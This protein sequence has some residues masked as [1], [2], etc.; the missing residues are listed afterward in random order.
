MKAGK[1]GGKKNNSG[2]NGRRRGKDTREK[3]LSVATRLFAR[4]GFAGT[5][6]DEIA[7]EVGIKKASLYHHFSSKHEIYDE[8]VKRVLSEIMQMFKKSFYSDDIIDDA[9][10]F[11]KEVSFFVAKNDDYLKILVREVLDEN[12]PIRELSVKYLPDLLSAGAEILEKG[13]KKGVFRRNIDPIHLSITIT[14]S[15]LAFFLFEPL[16]QPFLRKNVRNPNTIMERVKHISD[17]ILYGIVEDGVRRQ[18]I[19]EKSRKGGRQRKKEV[20]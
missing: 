9:R 13:K 10:N 12:I 8:L 6:M 11:M 4:K 15:V 7:D 14:G 2:K 20:S 3:I 5:S 18:D 19:E 16:I 1:K 17:V